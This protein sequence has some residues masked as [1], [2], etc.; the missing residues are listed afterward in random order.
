ME[1]GAT[2]VGTEEMGRRIAESIGRLGA[3]VGAAAA[4]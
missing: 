3:R 4:R 1:P 2:L